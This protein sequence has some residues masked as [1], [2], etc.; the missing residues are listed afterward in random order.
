MYHEINLIEILKFLKG[1]LKPLI[2]A[3]L[4]SLIMANVVYTVMP[5]QYQVSFN[6]KPISSFDKEAYTSFNAFNVEPIDMS[7]LH[8][9]FLERVASLDDIISSVLTA[10]EK[11]DEA[12]GLA[13]RK[14]VR[15]EYMLMAAGREDKKQVWP[16]LVYH[17]SDPSAATEIIQ[18]SLKKSNEYIRQNQHALFTNRMA[19]KARQNAYALEDIK[20][21]MKH[22]KADYERN[23][24]NRLAFLKEQAQIAH[25][26]N[27]AQNTMTT[28]SFKTAAEDHPMVATL[29]N[30]HPYYLYGYKG[31]EKEIDLMNKRVD[32]QAFTA[33]LIDLEH[34]Q[35]AIETDATFQR[36]QALFKLLPLAQPALF[37]AADLD[38]SQIQEM[39]LST[40]RKEVSLIAIAIGMMLGLAIHFVAINRHHFNQI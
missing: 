37:K 31:I 35:R 14:K 9:L 2:F 8:Q 15:F 25:A 23:T 17:G 10:E 24:H 1:S 29:P 32:K 6:L 16:R 30:D 4:G 19:I 5:K 13:A 20:R 33:G 7:R 22:A 40:S 36:A 34:K 39:S 27:V 26:L 21:D 18:T 11:K 38:F 12:K 28:Q 3:T